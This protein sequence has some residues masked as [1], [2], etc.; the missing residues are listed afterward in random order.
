MKNFIS[1]MEEKIKNVINSLGYN[2]SDVD[3][4]PSSRKEF[5]DFQYNGVMAIAKS[6]GK[7][8]RDIATDIADKLNELDECTNVNVAGP[9][10]INITFT[11]EALKDYIN[12]LKDDINISYEYDKPKTIFLDYGGAN[13]AKALHVGHLRSAN[14]GEALKRLANALGNKT[15]SDV[16]LGDWG[17]PL[18]LVILEIKKRHPELCYFD[19][20]FNGE[21]PSDF[22]ITNDDLMEIYP[23]A[24]NKAKEDE[25]YLEEAREVTKKLQEG[26]K[27]YNELWKKIMEVSTNDIKK[28][29]DR[30]NTTFDLWEGESNCYKKIPEMMNYLDKLNITRESE[31]AIV[32]DVQKDDD[33]LEYPPM[34]LVKSNG[35]ASYQTTDLAGIFDRVK[36]FNPDEI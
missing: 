32:I 4:I 2:V 13:V 20:N 11:N 17:R 23:T 15:I 30:L 7:N 14:I 19:D 12:E 16:H 36:R 31:G 6:L 5:G 22:V 27:G 25:D 10:F 29:Y 1:K 35:G 18:G 21:Y 8:P 34:M 9:G 33:T 26:H 28:T 24:S 3:L